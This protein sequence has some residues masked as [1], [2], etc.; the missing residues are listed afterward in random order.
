MVFA[1]QF[2][3]IWKWFFHFHDHIGFFVHFRF[4]VDESGAVSRAWV[5][6]TMSEGGTAVDYLLDRCLAE[7]LKGL[8]FPPSA[9]D[10]VYTW[11]FATRG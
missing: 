10:G 2:I 11:V 1:K 6:S 9:G 4:R 3:F 5:A 8:H 7:T